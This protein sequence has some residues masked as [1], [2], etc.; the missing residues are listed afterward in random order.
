MKSRSGTYPARGV[1]PSVQHRQHRP[2]GRRNRC[3]LYLRN[4]AN[5]V[6]CTAVGICFV[7]SLARG[8]S[9]GAF[10]S[11]P[12]LRASDVL[13]QELLAGPYH[14][15][16]EAVSNDGYYNHYKIHTV[17]G[18]ITVYGTDLLHHTI[19]E[20]F[21]IAQIEK[22]KRS[23]AFKTSFGKAV[24]QHHT[25]CRPPKVTVRVGRVRQSTGGT[26]GVRSRRKGDC[27]DRP[28]RW[29]WRSSP[30]GQGS[31]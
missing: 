10:E 5:A 14:R 13:P 22:M 30:G 15:V 2:W 19:R 16:D 28:W 12:V 9:L 3:R 17:F 31:L 27:A 1:S 20:I 11:P 6:L 23:D 21:A 24:N 18:E 29:S 7:S 26:R 25:Q 4:L 8:Q